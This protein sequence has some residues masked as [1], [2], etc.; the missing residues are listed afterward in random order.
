MPNIESGL[1]KEK[2]PIDVSIIVVVYNQPLSLELILKSIRAQDFTGIKEVIVADDGSNIDLFSRVKED[3]DKSGMS[4][5]YV[6]QQ[7]RGIKPAEAR[8][9]GIKLAKGKYLIFLDG[10]MVP[11]LDLVRKHVESHKVPK[12]IVAGN[13]KWRGN[14]DPLIF[15]SLDGR[16]IDIALHE[17]DI[18]WPTD[19][20]SKKR[21]KSERARREEWLN[22]KNPWRVCISGNLSVPNAPEVRFDENYLGFGNEDMELAYR[23]CTQSGYSPLY[24]DDISAYHLES[25]Q[26]VTN[27]FRT[28]GHE[29]IVSHMRNMFYFF[30]KC[31]GLD[32]EEVFFGFPRLKLDT[33]T[34]EWR[35]IPRPQNYSRE[36]LEKKIS[37]VRDW[38]KQYE[39]NRPN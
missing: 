26:G 7:D 9:N 24:N 14:I 38:L 33:T 22:S 8:N 29:N 31:P 10:D 19:E 12:L 37:Q 36:L 21:E 1:S 20:N 5:K 32:I 6:W 2:L 17:L 4:I 11:G 35:V 28:G 16:P 27:I 15:E 23:L 13:R 30:D 3:F 34:N 39:H 18:N 25:P